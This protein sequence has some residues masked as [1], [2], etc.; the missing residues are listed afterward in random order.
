ME[1]DIF[2]K[3]RHCDDEPFVPKDIDE[4][5]NTCVLQGWQIKIKNKKRDDSNL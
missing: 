5:D 1:K 4:R 2:P 3:K